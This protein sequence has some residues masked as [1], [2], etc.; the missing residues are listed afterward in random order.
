MARKDEWSE[1]D[2]A[3]FGALH[4]LVKGN[5]QAEQGARRALQAAELALEREIERLSSKIGAVYQAESM[6]NSKILQMKTWWTWA[7]FLFNGSIFVFNLYLLQVGLGPR[8]RRGEVQLSESTIEKLRLALTEPVAAAIQPE[9]LAADLPATVDVMSEEHALGPLTIHGGSAF[10]KSHEVELKPADTIADLKDKVRAVENL[11][12]AG[13][14]F[15]M[16]GAE[17]QDTMVLEDLPVKPSH[18]IEIFAAPGVVPDADSSK[19]AAKEKTPS[20]LLSLRGS[21]LVSLFSSEQQISVR[22][23][24]LTALAL[25][26]AFAGA[27]LASLVFL[28]I[29]RN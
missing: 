3:H 1:T 23:S 22:V 9:D 25:Q 6:Y 12:P 13:L 21:Q 17:L 16:D 15:T 14:R 20:R 24:V 2:A 28:G 5:E 19:P 29:R 26:S 7:L 27:A 18:T 10:Y 8:S 4:T 11:G